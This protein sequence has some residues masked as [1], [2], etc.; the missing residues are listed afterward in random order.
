MLE[1]GSGRRSDPIPYRLIA[2][3]A[4]L[5]ALL[6]PAGKL[7]RAPVMCPFRRVTGLPCPTCGLSRSWTALLHGHP[8]ESISFH[9]LGPL[10]AAAAAFFA[11]GI[12]EASPE[13]GA[14]LRSRPL[15]G[16]AV[17]AWVAVWLSRLRAARS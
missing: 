2:G 17:A 12:H 16:A 4:L 6:V 14:R 1:A 10:T 7:D 3:L 11:L 13:L 9:P 15:L 5:A 8:R